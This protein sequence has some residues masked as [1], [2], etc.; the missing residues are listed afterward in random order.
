MSAAGQYSPPF[1]L[2]ARK[3]MDDSLMKDEPPQS[4]D[5]ATGNEWANDEIFVKWLK[6]FTN[7]TKASEENKC[8]LIILDGHYSHKTLE[9]ITYARQHV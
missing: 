8:Q 7:V 3:T 2:F 6:H 1:F 5:H 9:A 4:K